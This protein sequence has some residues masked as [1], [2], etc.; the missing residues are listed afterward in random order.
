MP[1]AS[2]C[3]PNGPVPLQ[4]LPSDAGVDLY[5]LRDG[6]IARLGTTLLTTRSR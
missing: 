5:T 3:A 2:E 6:R 1:K 4:F